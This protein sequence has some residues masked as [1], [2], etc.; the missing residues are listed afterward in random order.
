MIIA[1][2]DDDG[3]VLKTV[4]GCISHYCETNRFLADV[5]A[6]RSGEELLDA[7]SQEPIDL[8]FLDVYMGGMTGVETARKIRETDP[9]CILVFMTVSD[10]FALDAYS[11]D[12][13]AYLRKPVIEQDVLRVLGKCIGVFLKNSRFITIPIGRRD[14]IRL[15]FAAIRFVEVF[16]KEV[17]FHSDADK[18]STMRMSLDE[19]ERA[20]GGSPFLRCHRSFIVNMNYVEKIR[21]GAFLMKNA[22]TVPIGKNR[23]AEIRSAFSDFIARVSFWELTP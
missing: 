22:A 13:I 15:P 19:V 17:V 3:A 7:F 16:D 4:S 9:A 12:G 2:C 20:L 18:I 14:E 1:V 10:E 21:N 11:L 8:I 6:Y 5:R 23:Y